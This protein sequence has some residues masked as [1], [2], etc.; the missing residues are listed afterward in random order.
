V[1][2]D[3]LIRLHFSGKSGVFLCKVWVNDVLAYEYGV[4]FHADYAGPKSAANATTSAGYG[5]ANGLRVVVDK[6]VD[7]A[8]AQSVAVVYRYND[9]TGRTISGMFQF[10]CADS[11]PPILDS[12][13]LGKGSA[14]ELVLTFSEPL[15]T[16]E[17]TLTSTDGHVP[18]ISDVTI[19]GAAVRVM[20]DDELS[21]QSTYT[22]S[23]DVTDLAGNVAAIAMDTTTENFHIDCRGSMPEYWLSDLDDDDNLAKLCDLFSEVLS[24][25]F[26]DVDYFRLLWDY[27]EC[28]DA[29]VDAMIEGFG[30]DGLLTEFVSNRKVLSVL[31]DI[32]RR[33]GI[34]IDLAGVINTLVGVRPY[35]EEWYDNAF[36]L[37]ASYLDGPDHLIGDREIDP[38]EFQLIFGSW[39]EGKFQLDGSCL[40]GPDSLI[41]DI[42]VD[43][44]VVSE[45]TSL[46]TAQRQTVIRIVRAI[47]PANTMFK[48]VEPESTPVYFQLNES[49]LDG[50]HGLS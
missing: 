28:Y 9:V 10:Q 25:S 30:A 32:Y 21:F 17:I 45:Y 44:F 27:D 35:I 14:K 33:K 3:S 1:P 37:D 4:G 13:V 47:K 15:A 43:P 20:L 36:Q 22:V 8:S 5:A 19:T 48:I 46:T 6:T 39:F 38:F 50:P 11:T 34:K 16:A 23:A 2:V 18:T 24:L 26:K 12:I 7:F 40:D 42:T 41:G 29:H 49:Y 31:F